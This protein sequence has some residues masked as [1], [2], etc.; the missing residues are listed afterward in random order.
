M[1]LWQPIQDG[2]GTHEKELTIIREKGYAHYFLVVDEIV[3]QAPRTCG[4][5]SAA[6]SIVSYCLGI[7]HVDPIRHHLLF[8][9]FLNP[10]R[11]DPPDIDLDFPWD[12][13]PQILEWVFAHYG[14]RQAAMVANQNTLAIRAALREIAKVY[15]IPATEIGK[16]LRL[17]VSF[18]SAYLRTHYPAEFIAAVVSNQGGY[19]STFAYLSEGRRMGLTIR[20]IDINESDWAYTGSGQ[21]VRVGLMQIKFL[22]EE[23]AK[24]IITERRAN[25]PYRS[26]RDFLDRERPELAQAKLLIK[27]GSF[28]SIAGELTR[29]ALL[30]RLFTSQAAKPPGYL[31]IPAEYAIQQKLA[32]ELEFFGFPLRCHPLDIFKEMLAHIPHLPVK[33]LALH[34]GE[35]VTAVGWLLTE[36]IISTKKGVP[37]EFITFEDQTGLYDATLFPDVYRQYCH[38]L[39]PNHAYVVTGRVEEQLSTLTLTVKDLK[40]L[41]SR[42]VKGQLEPLEEVIS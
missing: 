19:Y 16:A 32:H 12:E 41:A 20:P 14:P 5:G 34:V 6:A 15:G 18:K 22:Q 4:R 25:G 37:M 2:E 28:D 33:N 26:L 36:K 40:L 1:A 3:R 23:L 11:H 21:T 17:Q 9:R 35:E 7:T 24:R 39:A 29:P 31:P 30:W 8:E 38:L 27:A 42:D 10:S 13:R